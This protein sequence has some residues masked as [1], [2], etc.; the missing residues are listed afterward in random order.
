MK[1][2]LTGHIAL[3]TGASRGLGEAIAHA[4]AE[5][6]ATVALAARDRT[7][8]EAAQARIEAAGGHA[9]NFVADVTSEADVAR[10]VEEVEAALGAPDILV[11]NAG[12][13]IRKNL[14]DFTTAEFRQVVDASLLS[15]FLVTRAFV[16]GMTGRGYGR[17]INLA[18]MLSHVSLPQR[19]AYSAA[20]TALLGFTRALALELAPEA[21]TI[22]A[23]SPGPIATEMNAPVMNDPQASASFMANLPL[24]RW[25]RPEEVGGLACYLCS[26]LAGFITGTDVVMD[27][28]WTAR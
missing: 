10:L 23:I 15:T 14:V 18:S 5:S 25:G 17:V 27:G 20:K 2:D 19:T 26:D 9:A 16:P 7:R 28:G 8:L 11:N 4:L 21:I 22:N 12:I 13:N 6:G 24:G 3:V 1:I